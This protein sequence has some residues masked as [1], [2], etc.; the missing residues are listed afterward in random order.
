MS[1]DTLNSGFMHVRGLIRIALWII[2]C[3]AL[4]WQT[5]LEGA[6]ASRCT[7][8]ACTR[9]SFTPRLIH[10]HPKS[11]NS[12]TLPLLPPHGHQHRQPLRASRNRK[13]TPG[14][15]C[16]SRWQCEGAGS[17]PGRVKPTP[18]L[19]L[20]KARSYRVGTGN[21][22]GASRPSEGAVQLRLHEV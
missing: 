21:K 2:L 3:R 10:A 6:H 13:L 14:G 19:G 1:N 7:T 12:G 16:P 11:G 5:V 4:Y 15:T 8:V 20:G 22:Q 18:K 17:W 9:L